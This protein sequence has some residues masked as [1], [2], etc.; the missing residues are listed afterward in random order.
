[1]IDLSSFGPCPPTT[2]ELTPRLQAVK[3]GKSV[4]FDDL[5]RYESAVTRSSD[6]LRELRQTEA[7]AA[8]ARAAASVPATQMCSQRWRQALL[9]ACILIGFFFSLL[10]TTIVSTSLLAASEDLSGFRDSSWVVLAYLLTYMGIGGAGLYSLTTIALPEVGPG[11]RPEIIGKIIGITLSVSFIIG[12]ILGGIIPQISTWRVIYWLNAPFAI[13]TITGL[14]FLFPPENR[15][16]LGPR[17][18]LGRLDIIG[19][20][21]L[22]A[23]TVLL[24]IA[25]QEAGSLVVAWNSLLVL[26]SLTLA[27]VSLALFIGWESLLWSGSN[28]GIEPVFPLR[29]LQNRVYS[30][31][32]ID[33]FLIGCVYL[34]LVITVPQRFQIVNGASVFKTGV[35]LLPML[36]GTAGGCLVSGPIN[37]K[38]N[39]TAPVVV[40]SC[41]FMA[42]STSLL[43]TV[44][45]I[46]YPAGPMYGFLTLFGFG[47]G[48]FMSAGTMLSTAQASTGD[49]A[50]AQGAISQLRLLG[51]ILGLTS[52]TIIFN[53]SIQS[54]DMADGLSPGQL[55]VLRRSPSALVEMWPELQDLIRGTYCAAFHK[56]ASIMAGVTGLALLVSLGTL[57][58]SPPPIHGSLADEKAHFPDRGTSDM[59]LDDEASD[60][61]LVAFH[62]PVVAEPLPTLST[63]RR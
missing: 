50:V 15:S 53:S 48:L 60:R 54:A 31:C 56:M 37:A 30:A 57:E 17:R 39:R 21:L 29:L 18:S 47:F 28:W 10:D 7:Q 24:V 46:D 8:Q 16:R 1:M 61:S 63:N 9:M 27:A 40:V 51:G 62:V 25:L 13:V 12:P 22:L 52:F 14:V 41:V 45:R 33:K 44:N 55:E 43:A 35:H 34:C 38:K 32:L 36:G 11:H 20:F 6:G 2:R 58:K 5:N 49:H 3:Y 59:K 23:S 26:V 42:V 4:S 19:S